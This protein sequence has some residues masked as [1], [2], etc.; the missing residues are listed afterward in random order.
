[1]FLQDD[2][3][4]IILKPIILDNYYILNQ[5]NEYST[6]MWMYKINVGFVYKLQ[7]LL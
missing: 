2:R 6:R 1:M 3:I 7:N 4:R 5:Y